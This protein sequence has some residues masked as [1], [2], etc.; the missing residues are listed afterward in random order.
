MISLHF[1]RS[2]FAC[3][4]GCG[5]DTVDVE[6][7]EVLEAVRHHFMSPVIITSGC[8]CDSHNINVGGVKNS[9]HTK[10]RAVDFKVRGHEPKEVYTFLDKHYKGKFGIGLYSS[11]VHVD[12]RTGEHSRWG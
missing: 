6:V 9:Y 1:K 8:R 4:C 3:R 10:A 7:I 12:T 11:W 5:F 2:E